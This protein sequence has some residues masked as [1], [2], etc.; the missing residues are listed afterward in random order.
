MKFR[1]FR[2]GDS[3]QTF[4]NLTERIK[5]EINSLENEYVLK[6]S[7]T[8]LEEYF[9]DKARIEPLTLHTDKYYIENQ[10]GIKIDVSHDYRQAVFPG[11][12]AIVQ[13][14]S[15]DI[16]I[17]FEGDKELWKIQPSRF[18]LSGYPEIEVRDG[19]IILTFSFPDDSA[20][21]DRLK[22]QIKSQIKSLADAVNNLKQDVENHNNS[23]QGIIKSALEGKRQK[24]LGTTNAIAGDPRQSFLPSGDR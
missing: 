8:E 23:V 5:E 20:D 11:E 13:G 12:R 4:R 18:T 24:A 15:L 7:A 16:A 17:P 9:L 22:N 6:A 21:S 19:I 10:G 1:P 3:L 14:T 2:D